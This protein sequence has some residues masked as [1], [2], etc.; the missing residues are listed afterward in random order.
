MSE[1]NCHPAGMSTG[2]CRRFTHETLFL[3]RPT[4][5]RRLLTGNRMSDG[6]TAHEVKSV[7]SGTLKSLLVVLNTDRMYTL[8]VQSSF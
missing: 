6:P 5:T 2:T 1:M 4:L 7:M 8:S 3:W